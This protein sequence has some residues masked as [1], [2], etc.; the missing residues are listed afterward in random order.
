MQ[1]PEF[2]NEPLCDF[3]GNA[4]LFKKMKAAIEEVGKEL[5]QEYDLVIG[6]QRVKTQDKLRSYNPSQKDQLVGS[7]SKA[8]PELAE[9]AI[10]TADEAFKT[11]SRTPA[12]AQ[13]G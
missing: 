4:E 9:R 7:F 11:W 10:K 12:E 13:P 5:G 8:N 1:L 6:G 3:Q 2:K